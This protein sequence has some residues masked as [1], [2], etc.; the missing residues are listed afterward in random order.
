MAGSWMA[1]E[2]RAL[3]TKDA[4]GRGVKFGSFG[5]FLLAECAGVGAEKVFISSICGCISGCGAGFGGLAEASVLRAAVLA[6]G[7]GDSVRSAIFALRCLRI[8]KRRSRA[9]SA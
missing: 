6:F 7:R 9:W 8:R 4:A 1:G 5:D 3:I 2:A